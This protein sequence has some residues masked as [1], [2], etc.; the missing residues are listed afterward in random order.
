VEGLAGSLATLGIELGK[1]GL[2]VV[3]PDPSLQKTPF[4]S[5]FGKNLAKTFT[6]LGPTFIKLGQ[7]LATRPD[8][9]GEKV[10]DELK[11]LFDSVKPLPFKTIQK[12][13]YQ[14]LGPEKVR[15]FFLSIEPVSLA[16]A[17]IS[18]THR[19]VLKEGTPVIIKVQKPGTKN[20][21]ETDLFLMEGLVRSLDLLYP[22]AH[23]LKTF[24]DF[25]EAT[26]NE[27]DYR[28]EA[29]NIEKFRKNY[30]KFLSVPDVIF[31]SYYPEV[32]TGKVL[33]LEPMRGKKVGELKKGSTV[34]RNAASKSI[35]AVLEQIF[36]HGFFHADPHAGNLFFLEEEGQLG[37]IDMGL[38]GQ[39]QKEDK[40]KFLKVI[41]AVIKKDKRQLARS[42]FNLSQPS[43][44]SDYAEFEKAIENF[45]NQTTPLS[46]SKGLDQTINE[47]LKIAKEH[48]L[49]IPNRYLLMLRSCL[50]IEGLVKSLDPGL[51]VLE[52]ARPI[53][54]KSLIKSYN[55]VA[56]IR[57]LF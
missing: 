57:K 2:S 31:P 7:V 39:L 44:K 48:D 27:T 9:V 37:F 1:R 28:K 36:E 29:K 17:S 20:I 14:E 3:R 49:F 32:S 4:D 33:V 47:L 35:A 23:I 11:I 13:I 10:A 22:K 21:I 19:G 16:C 38:V 43:K 51:S 53:I 41:F 45:L 12:I 54:A 30:R 25:K 18:Q 8:L 50:I 26:L 52:M 40:E 55:P 24:Q 34:A 46:A 15:K 5:V 6:R 42:L 56:L